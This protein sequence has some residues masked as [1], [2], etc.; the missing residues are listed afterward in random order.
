MRMLWW[1]SRL[2]IL[3]ESFSNPSSL[4]SVI[5]SEAKNLGNIHRLNSFMVKGQQGGGRTPATI[6]L[7]IHSLLQPGCRSV[8]SFGKIRGKSRFYIFFVVRRIKGRLW[9]QKHTYICRTGL[10][11][12]SAFGNDTT[13]G[14]ADVGGDKKSKRGVNAPFVW[15]LNI[16][17]FP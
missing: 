7:L 11:L 14:G 6:F 12:Y 17:P 9:N 8:W 5:L 3:Q 4:H 2:N 10:W 16:P 1:A 13:G 15:L